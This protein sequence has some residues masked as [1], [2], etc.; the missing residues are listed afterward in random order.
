VCGCVG[1][2]VCVWVCVCM[3]VQCQPIS[4][5]MFLTQRFVCMSCLCG[6]RGLWSYPF[7]TMLANQQPVCA[8]PYCVDYSRHTA[9]GQHRTSRE[10]ARCVLMSI[11]SYLCVSAFYLS[12]V[13]LCMYVCIYLSIYLSV[14]LSI[15]SVSSSSQ[16]PGMCSRRAGRRPTVSPSIQ[17]ALRSPLATTSVNSTSGT[18]PISRSA[19]NSPQVSNFARVS[20]IPP[21]LILDVRFHSLSLS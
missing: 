19:V 17:M 15:L 10:T 20:Y 1:V 6:G 14:Y 3:C 18:W 9:S 21:M 8:S 4:S 2:W 13:C 16:L 5:D 7:V 12:T 11:Y